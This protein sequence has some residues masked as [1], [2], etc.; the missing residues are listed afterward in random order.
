MLKESTTYLILFLAPLRR[1]RTTTAAKETPDIRRHH[2]SYNFSYD[3]TDNWK[4]LW[5][6]S[7]VVVTNA[8]GGLGGRAALGRCARRVMTPKKSRNA[9]DALFPLSALT[10]KPQA[11]SHKPQATCLAQKMDFTTERP[12]NSV[13]ASTFTSC[14]RPGY[15]RASWLN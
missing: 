1:F 13:T 4:V 15:S 7:C 6:N 14:R 5:S 11:A 12:R 9:R 8:I 10:H 3:T 2:N